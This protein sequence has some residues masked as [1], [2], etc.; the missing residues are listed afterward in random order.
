MPHQPSFKLAAAALCAAVLSVMSFA[1][2]Q[3]AIKPS[4]PQGI[5][6]NR[7]SYF[8]AVNNLPAERDRSKKSVAEIVAATEDG[9][10]LAYTDGEQ[11]AL[12]LVDIRDPAQ[13]KPAGF[14]ALDGEPTSV[15]ITAGKALVA[16]NTSSRFVQPEGSL[17]VIDLKTRAIVERCT[18]LGQPDSLALDVK[19]QHV[20][21]AIENERDEALN[22][23]EIP[24]TPAGHVSIIPLK[25]GMPDCTQQF[26]IRWKAWQK[27]RPAILSQSL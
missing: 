3:Q 16:V 10:L 1:H 4:Q 7:I 24:Q 12:G 23:G 17:V 8:A 2:A 27:S 13:P 15:V 11:K 26:P 5:Y 9:M 22:K 20:V 19:A 25:R 6:F 14:I 21:I 18:L